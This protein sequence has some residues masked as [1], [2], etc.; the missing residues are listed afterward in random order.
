[1]RNLE[2]TWYEPELTPYIDTR[3]TPWRTLLSYQLLF[4]GS[5]SCCAYFIKV[6]RRTPRNSLSRCLFYIFRRYMFRPYCATELLVTECEVLPCTRANSWLWDGQFR[7][8]VGIV[9]S[10]TKATELV[11]YVSALVGHPQLLI[12]YIIYIYNIYLTPWKVLVQ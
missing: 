8:S 2:D 7:L 1:M 6:I 12:K 11:R 5:A 9:R 4:W 3:I 10:R